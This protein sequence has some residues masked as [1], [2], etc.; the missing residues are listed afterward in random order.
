MEE[1]E[2]DIPVGDQ[3]LMLIKDRINFRHLHNEL[4]GSAVIVSNISEN[5]LTEKW[6]FQPPVEGFT[7]EVAT[8]NNVTFLNTANIQE[9]GI[10]SI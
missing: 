5:V 10:H 6:S 4:R 9:E 1:V 8:L 2:K 7:D 3:Y